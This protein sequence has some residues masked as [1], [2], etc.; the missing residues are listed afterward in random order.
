M[1]VLTGHL[2][3]EQLRQRG[4]ARIADGVNKSILNAKIHGQKCVLIRRYPMRVMKL[5]SERLESEGYE[6][7]VSQEN[8]SL[9]IMWGE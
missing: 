9:M 1:V 6:T 5:I 8:K 3:F 2:K 4:E 7:Y